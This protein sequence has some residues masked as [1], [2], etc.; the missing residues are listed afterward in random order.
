M[1]EGMEEVLISFGSSFGLDS[2]T[3]VSR[4][5]VASGSMDEGWIRENNST[6]IA[7]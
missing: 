3:T 1:Q 4:V 2:E 5:G 6:V 7:E